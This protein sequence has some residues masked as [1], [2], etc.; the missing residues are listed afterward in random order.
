LS[1]LLNVNQLNYGSVYRGTT[2]SWVKI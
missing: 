1:Y 2:S